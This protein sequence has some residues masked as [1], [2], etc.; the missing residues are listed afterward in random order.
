MKHKFT[1]ID[2]GFFLAR[3]P[4]LPLETFNNWNKAFDKGNFVASSYR[5]NLLCDALYIASPTLHDRFHEYFGKDASIAPE[6]GAIPEGGPAL[7]GSAPLANVAALP[8]PTPIPKPKLAL[9]GSSGSGVLPTATPPTPKIKAAVG[10]NSASEKS[11]LILALS[12]YLSRAAYRCTPFGLFAT[13]TTGEVGDMTQLSSLA[14]APLNAR[15]RYDASLQANIINW[16]LSDKVFREK[17]TY[18]VNSSLRSFFMLKASILNFIN[19][20]SSAK[21]NGIVIWMR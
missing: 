9:D 12:R 21:W 2:Q 8:Q 7:E 13:V 1:L 16:L 6:S 17:L 10:T 15:I 19:R 18:R 14:D 5:N 20:M 4:L 3:A 11:K